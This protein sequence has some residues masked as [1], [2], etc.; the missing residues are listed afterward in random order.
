MIIHELC[1]SCGLGN[2]GNCVIGDAGL[3]WEEVKRVGYLPIYLG[4]QGRCS[5]GI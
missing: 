2:G 5:R 1:M 4:G 3:R